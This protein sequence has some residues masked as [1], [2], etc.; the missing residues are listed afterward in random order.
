MTIK[1]DLKKLQRELNKL[2][3]QTEKI[4]T[5]LNK[6]EAKKPAKPARATKTKAVAKKAVKKAV[7]AKKAPAKKK[8]SKVS[9]TQKVVDLVKGSDHSM[10]VRTLREKTGF[11]AKKISNILYKAT[12][13]GKVK[14]VGRGLYAAA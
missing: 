3:K 13:D 6:L 14:S 1:Q 5:S 4:A 11:N 8:T 10:D 9:D 7:P 2:A 12:K